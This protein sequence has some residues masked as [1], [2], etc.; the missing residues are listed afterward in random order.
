MGGREQGHD[1]GMGPEPDQPAHDVGEV[2]IGGGTD[3]DE[4]GALDGGQADELATRAGL[5][6]DLDAAR[7]QNRGD[8]GPDQ[9]EL[10]GH[11]RDSRR[12]PPAL[13]P[14]FPPE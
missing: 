1:G 5:G 4:V 12:V 11:Q 3:H 6:H 13:P 10:V 9:A 8:P 14:E 7:L 2:E